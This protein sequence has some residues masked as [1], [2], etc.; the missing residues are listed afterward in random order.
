MDIFIGEGIVKLNTVKKLKAIKEI[1]VLNNQNIFEFTKDDF[2]FDF[3][4]KYISLA[5]RSQ[6]YFDDNLSYYYFRMFY[7][8]NK[9]ILYYPVDSNFGNLCLPQKEDDES[10][11]FY[12]NL[13]LQNNYNEFLSNFSIAGTNQ[14][15]LFRIDYVKIYQ[16]NFMLYFK[17]AE[18]KYTFKKGGKENNITHFLF[19]FKFDNQEI[20]KIISAFYDEFTNIFPQIYS[21]QIYYLINKEKVFNYSLVYNYTFLVKYIDGWSGKVNL[22]LNF[23]K[24]KYI[25]ITRNFRGK[26]INLQVTPETKNMDFLVSPTSQIKEFIFYIELKYKMKNKLIEEIISGQT[27][28]EIMMDGNFPLLYFIDLKQKKNIN[29]DINIRLNSYDD[30]TLENDF[31][32]KGILLDKDLIERKMRGESIPDENQYIFL[33]QYIPSYKFGLLQINK[34]INNSNTSFIL[35]QINSKKQTKLKHIFWLKS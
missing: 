30:S 18:F 34:E 23:T 9:E 11:Q 28:S 15:E 21:S 27:R 17:D 32:I 31:D 2:E 26:P 16:S 20:K 13:I 1:N 8:R 25:Y 35:I 12:C 3:R 14:N 19:K 10:K 24:N 33:G 7:L 4:N 29:L 5:L 6:N 22:N